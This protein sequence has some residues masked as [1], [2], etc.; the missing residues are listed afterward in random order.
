MWPYWVNDV[1]SIPAPIMSLVS[2]P[3]IQI[4]TQFIPNVTCVIQTHCNV[5]NYNKYQ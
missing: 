4:Q 1:T 5:V 3:K 2:P